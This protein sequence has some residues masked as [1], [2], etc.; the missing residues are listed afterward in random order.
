SGAGRRLAMLA[1]RLLWRNWR[2]G[3]VKLLAFALF[4]AVAVVSGIAIFTDR[5]ERTLTKESNSVL[6]ADVI[7]RSPQPHD[8]AWSEAAAEAG[9]RQARA[10]VFA[11]MVFSNEH[12]HLASVK[13]VDGGYPLRGQFE[14]SQLPFAS[15]PDDIHVAEAVPA[16]GEAWVDSRL[17]PLLNVGLGDA[18]SVGEYSLKLTRILIREPDASSRVSIMGARRLV[19]LDELPRTEVVQEGSRVEYHWLLAADD[20]RLG[21]FLAWLKPRMNDHQRLVDVESAQQ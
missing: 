10:A 6:G 1:L 17:L 14:I 16:P 5:L 9:V 20:N 18:G 15:N 8:S 11:S 13:A 12:M 3:E 4:L 2:S 7:L 19:N 21:R